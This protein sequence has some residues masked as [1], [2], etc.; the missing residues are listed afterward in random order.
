[1]SRKEETKSGLFF[2]LVGLRGGDCDPVGFK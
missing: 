2:L 1:M